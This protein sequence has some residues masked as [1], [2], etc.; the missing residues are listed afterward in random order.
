MKFKIKD[1]IVIILIFL[2]QIGFGYLKAHFFVNVA[3]IRMEN[4]LKDLRG[5]INV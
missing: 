1:H 4:I 2:Q 5:K 3:I